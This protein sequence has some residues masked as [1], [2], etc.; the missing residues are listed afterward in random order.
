[1]H[2]DSEHND[3]LT[4]SKEPASEYLM[5]ILSIIIQVYNEVTTIETIIRRL[6]AV[7]LPFTKGIVVVVY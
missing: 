4:E 2:S 7:S 5:P 6:Q 1:M 3:P